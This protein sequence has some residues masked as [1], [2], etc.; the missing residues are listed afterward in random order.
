MV[1]VGTVKKTVRPMDGV[2]SYALNPPAKTGSLVWFR[3][4][5]QEI[6]KKSKLGDHLG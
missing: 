3:I 4:S 1:N 2:F 5:S 6:P